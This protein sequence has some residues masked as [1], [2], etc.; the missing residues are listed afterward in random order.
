M[1]FLTNKEFD[2][3]REHV[4]F[5]QVNTTMVREHVGKIEREIRTTKE[6]TQCTIGEFPFQTISTMVFLYTVYNMAL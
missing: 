3:V 4:P 6:R 5:L 1:L 2:A